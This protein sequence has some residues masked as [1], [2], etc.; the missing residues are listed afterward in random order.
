MLSKCLNC[1]IFQQIWEKI[2]KDRSIWINF[3]VKNV[4]TVSI[5]VPYK[6][7]IYAIVNAVFAM[8]ETKLKFCQLEPKISGI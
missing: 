8:L 4:V 7:Y 3:H 2:L 5:S 1:K 6:S